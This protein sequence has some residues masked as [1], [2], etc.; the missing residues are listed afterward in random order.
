MYSDVSNIQRRYPRCKCGNPLV[1]SHFTQYT[2]HYTLYNVHRRLYTVHYLLYTVHFTMY[3]VHRTPSACQVKV[4]VK[5]TADGCLG[6]GKL[7]G[8]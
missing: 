4:C 3:T 8:H 6:P 7:I 5:P 1:Q 2:V